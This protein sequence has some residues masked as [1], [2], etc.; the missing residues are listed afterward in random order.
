MG[1]DVFMYSITLDPAHDTP[2][3]LARYARAFGVGPGWLFLT[4]DAADLEALRRNLGY[5][6]PDPVEDKDR[7]QHIGMLRMGIEPLER[8]AAC[9]SLARPEWRSEEH[10]SELQS[11]TNL[12]CRLLLEKK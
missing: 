6:S 4:G 10:T 12:V 3:V 1:R 8:W 2:K 11:L 7:S 9:A 5:V